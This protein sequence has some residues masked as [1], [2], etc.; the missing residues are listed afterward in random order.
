MKKQW[1]EPTLNVEV[2]IDL[3]LI[4]LALNEVNSMAS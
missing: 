2:S 3:N 4:D 1:S